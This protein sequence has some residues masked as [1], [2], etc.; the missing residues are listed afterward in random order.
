MIK[1]QLIND[2]NNLIEKVTG[3]RF[4]PSSKSRLN[5]TRKS[6][7]THCNI[8]H[9]LDVGA[10]KGQYA[11]DIRRLGF[12]EQIYSFEPTSCYEHL[13]KASEGDAKW[14]TY[15]FGFGKTSGKLEM[16]I[17]SNNGE[18]SSLLKPKNIMAQGFGISFDKTEEVEIKTLKEFLDLNTISNIYLKIDTQGNEM[19]VL[20]GLSDRINCVSV[21]EF[22]SALISLYEGETGHYEI[23][24][25]LI[26]HG[27]K[28]KQMVI[29]HWNQNKETV[30]LDSIF[31][32]DQEL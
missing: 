29:T 23:A 31:V 16:Y 15:R 17:A 3:L 25:Y 21:I 13:A 8:K 28:V 30:S 22:E 11:Q 32:R 18:S 6:L 24:Q 12:K 9:V 10:N 14:Q 4:Q 1:N 19:N 20:L 27:F 26:N 5:S 7:L 2:V